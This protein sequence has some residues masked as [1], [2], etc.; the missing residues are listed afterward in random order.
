MKGRFENKLFELAR[1]FE[2]VVSVAVIIVIVVEFFR[3]IANSLPQMFGAYEEG[4]ITT[5]L[6]QALNLVVGIEFVKMLVRHSTNTITEVLLFATA[7]EMVVYHLQLTDTLLGVISIAILFIVRKF[8]L[9]EAVDNDKN[10]VKSFKE[11]R[12]NA[13]EYL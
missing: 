7:R 10:F 3:L 13:F 9:L 5:F 12:K 2:L 6:A 1:Y 8:L 4:F 11:A